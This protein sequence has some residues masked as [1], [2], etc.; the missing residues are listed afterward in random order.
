[1][2]RA[3]RAAHEFHKHDWPDCRRDGCRDEWP[4]EDGATFCEVCPLTQDENENDYLSLVR[5]MDVPL[6]T[7][8]AEWLLDKELGLTRFREEP[9]WRE[10]LAIRTVHAER[11]RIRMEK[12]PKDAGPEDDKP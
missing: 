2:K 1:M 4:V 5:A 7:F 3:V 8:A 12:K 9:L 10:Q 11:A 6:Y